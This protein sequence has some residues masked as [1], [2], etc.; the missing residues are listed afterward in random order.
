MQLTFAMFDVSETGMAEIAPLR[1]VVPAATLPILMSRPTEH[2]E[3]LVPSAEQ[4]IPVSEQEGHPLAEGTGA[5]AWLDGTILMGVR[6]GCELDDDD[7]ATMATDL[8]N[9]AAL[10]ETVGARTWMDEE[11]GFCVVEEGEMTGL[12]LDVDSLA[13]P[14]EIV[15]T[16]VLST[17]TDLP[18][19][20]SVTKLDSAASLSPPQFVNWSESRSGLLFAHFPP[21]STLLPGLGKATSSP[22]TVVQVPAPKMLA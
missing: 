13:L 22:S 14:I 12:A 17:G 18:L 2:T 16:S 19:P 11:D 15:T 20:D 10:L 7:A 3:K 6:S 4:T 1:Q 21:Y 9:T 8:L 5:A